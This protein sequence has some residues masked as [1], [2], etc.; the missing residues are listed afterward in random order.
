MRRR[1][2]CV[3]FDGLPHRIDQ[4]LS[5]VIDQACRRH[6]ADRAPAAA[7]AATVGVDVSDRWIVDGHAVHPLANGAVDRRHIGLRKRPRVQCG[8]IADRR[9]VTAIQYAPSAPMNA[10]PIHGMALTANR[11]F[12]G[13]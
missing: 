1:S 10:S 13:V 4:H 7:V 12:G 8:T 6:Q 3:W 11:A 9:V 5:S 2:L